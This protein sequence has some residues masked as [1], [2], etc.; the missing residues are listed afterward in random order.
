ML[1]NVD[2]MA[3]ENEPFMTERRSGIKSSDLLMVLMQPPPS[4][5]E[6]FDAWYDTEHLPERIVLPGFHSGARYICVDGYPR[7]M[8]LYDLEN[9]AVL[10]SDSWIWRFQAVASA[11]GPSA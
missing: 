4:M 5:E 10:E 1:K 9:E 3:R 8:A 7:Y 11:R 6:E 2:S